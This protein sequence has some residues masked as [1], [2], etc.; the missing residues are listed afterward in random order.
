MKTC[1]EEKRNKLVGAK[2]IICVLT[3]KWE[4]SGIVRLQGDEVMKSKEFKCLG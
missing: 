3:S 2:W 1:A 4:D